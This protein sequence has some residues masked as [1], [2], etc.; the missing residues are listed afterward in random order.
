[1]ADIGVLAL[2]GA[3]AR[4]ADVLARLGRRAVFVRK[5]EQL[6]ALA[7]LILPGGESSVQLELIAR[8]GLEPSL[9]E[10]AASGKPI[11]GTCAGLILLAR[12]VRNPAS[13][14]S[15]HPTNRTLSPR[16]PKS[17]VWSPFPARAE[18]T[19]STPWFRPSR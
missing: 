12:H 15:R 2:Q 14:S 16:A 17:S 5:P 4:H 8:A 18:R 9:R 3:F 19:R 7:G 1:M 11:L 10:F 6:A 13:S